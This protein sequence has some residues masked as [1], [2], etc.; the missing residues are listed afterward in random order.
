[1]LAAHFTPKNLFFSFAVPTLVAAAA[2]FVLGLRL[3]HA[4]A[5]AVEALPAE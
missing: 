1:L 2:M 5:A 3:R 4:R